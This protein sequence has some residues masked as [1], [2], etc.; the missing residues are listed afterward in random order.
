M[1][2]YCGVVLAKLGVDAGCEGKDALVPRA[3]DFGVVGDVD[4]ADHHELHVPDSIMIL[5]SPECPSRLTGHLLHQLPTG[6]PEPLLVL[7][8]TVQNH[9][10]RDR[11]D[12]VAGVLD[13]S[14]VSVLVLRWEKDEHQLGPFLPLA[15][16]VDVLSDDLREIVWSRLII[17]NL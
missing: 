6:I 2:A 7:H 5:Q 10:T 8:S 12:A 16:W 11:H 14:V 13:Y 3:L 17:R 15:G 1:R 4:T 9:L